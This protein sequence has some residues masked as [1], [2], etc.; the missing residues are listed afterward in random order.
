[1]KN[2]SLNSRRS[3]LGLSVSAAAGLL[4]NACEKTNAATTEPS[5]APA[6]TANG[7]QCRPREYEYPL[8]PWARN[9]SQIFVYEWQNYQ[10]VDK[11]LADIR[12][13]DTVTRGIPKVVVLPGLQKA[14]PG[15]YAPWDSHWPSFSPFR[16]GLARP[17]VNETSDEA[18]RW[19]MTEAKTKHN[20]RVTFHLD[21]NGVCTHDS[22]FQLYKDNGLVIFGDGLDDFPAVINR[23]REFE[24]GFFQKRID[25]IVQRFP[26]LKE[27]KLVKTDFNIAYTGKNYSLQ[28]HVTAEKKCMEYLK[29]QHGI[30]VITELVQYRHPEN[31]YGMR[32]MAMSFWADNHIG[33]MDAPAY[34]FCGGGSQGATWEAGKCN[35][36]LTELLFG[37]TIQV[38]GRLPLPPGSEKDYCDSPEGEYKLCRDFCYSILAWYYLNRLLRDSYEENHEVQFSNGVRSFVEIYGAVS[39]TRDGEYIRQGGDIFIPAL[40]RN[41]REIMAWSELGYSNRRWKLPPEWKGVEKVDV[42]RNKLAEATIKE[43]GIAVDEQGY[44]ALSMDQY[45]GVIVVPAGADTNDYG[46]PPPPSGKVKF[47]GVDDA[48]KGSWQGKYGQDGHIVVGDESLI[49]KYAGLSFINGETV[50]VRASTNEERALQRP[51]NP[52]DRLIAQ[53]EHSLHEVVDVRVAGGPKKVALYFCDFDRQNR[54]MTVDVVDADTTDVLD[55]H[56]LN[57]FPEGKYFLY[58]VDGHVQFRLTKFFYDHYWNPGSAIIS[59]IFFDEI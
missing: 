27:T 34:I 29:K 10:S 12:I 17:G 59:G 25:A 32:P 26:E 16:D 41:N 3:F 4:S 56:I 43:R 33:K 8:Y 19:L 1:M 31:L 35:F 58:E 36:P 40:W 37:A 47:L 49:P 2:E 54:Q 46:A 24:L 14:E 55:S 28:D 39:I 51:S 23:K 20:T 50:I 11:I 42:Y 9:W 44:L 52:R 5:S 48:T 18:V 30:E 15:G 21:L 57:N 38:E 53:R 13:V 22:L 6:Q 7:D 45:T